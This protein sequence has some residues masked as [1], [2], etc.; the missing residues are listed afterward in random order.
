VNTRAWL[1]I[2]D[3]WKAIDDRI[4][5]DLPS[6][7]GDLGGDETALA[8]GDL[9]KSL[10]VE[11]K[12][13]TEALRVILTADRAAELGTSGQS[14]AAMKDVLKPEVDREIQEMLAPLTIHIDERVLRKLSPSLGAS[15]NRLQHDLIHSDDGGA[16]FYERLGRLLDST[17][18][19]PLVLEV[20]AFCLSAG[21]FGRHLDE[22][23]KVT[24]YRD[25][26]ARALTTPAA[27]AS[28]EPAAA[29]AATKVRAPAIYYVAGVIL[30]IVL[31][32]IL[33]AAFPFPSSSSRATTTEGSHA[34]GTDVRSR[35]TAR[36]VE[37]EAPEP[38]PAHALE[39]T[40]AGR[41]P[42]SERPAADAVVVNRGKVRQRQRGIS[43]RPPL[44]RQ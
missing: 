17:S 30:G 31:V 12:T 39:S 37:P 34:A 7:K 5:R 42:G 14:D 44:G 24:S 36:S 11:L 13:L 25:R 16:V 9:R 15:W 33:R 4:A 18:S 1:R 23:E 41:D 32:V 8:L 26:L 19:S 20:Y 29:K 6:G 28:E 38:T 22:P 10:A 27:A 2:L 3:S 21:F 43:N 40:P 35:S